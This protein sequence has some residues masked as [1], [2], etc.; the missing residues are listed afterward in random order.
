M[1]VSSGTYLVKVYEC[2]DCIDGEPRTGDEDIHAE[3]KWHLFL[4][5]GEERPDHCPM[6]G[7]YL[8]LGESTPML[9]SKAP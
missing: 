5:Y 7:S 8:S 2:S 4:L 3:S 6:C 9:L 1:I